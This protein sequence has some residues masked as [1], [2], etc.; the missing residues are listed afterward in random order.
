MKKSAVISRIKTLK[1]LEPSADFKLRSKSTILAYCA[2]HQ[3]AEQFSPRSVFAPMFL[4]LG[5]SVASVTMVCVLGWY[6]ILSPLVF[7]QPQS[8]N[9]SSINNEWQLNDVSPYLEQIFSSDLA[10]KDVDSALN[11]LA[12][13]DTLNQGGAANAIEKEAQLINLDEQLPALNNQEI[14][15][16]LKQL[17]N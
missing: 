11:Q 14:D 4:K 13:Q 15:D 5:A 7:P 1:A 3:H 17:S 16:I 10:A 9:I 2:T 12:F 6:F 8:L